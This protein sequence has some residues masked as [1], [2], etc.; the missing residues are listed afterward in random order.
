MLAHFMACIW[1]YVGILSHSFYAESWILKLNLQNETILTQY[2]YSFY[3]AATTMV[4]V[5][6][7]DITG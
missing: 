1:Y 7:G 5:G 2:S 6:Y 3:W 4:T